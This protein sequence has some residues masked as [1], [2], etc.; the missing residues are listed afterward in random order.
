MSEKPRR[1]LAIIVRPCFEQDLQWVQL[2]YAHHVLT[3]AGTFDLTAPPLET[4]R[5]AW[6]EIA[7]KGWPYLVACAAADPSRI[8]GYA[9]AR[10][11]RDRAGYAHTFEDSI[12][13]SHTHTGFGIG[14]AMLSTLLNDLAEVGARQVVAVI[15][16]ADN[17]AS[18]R[19]HARF[20]FQEQGRLRDVGVKFGRTWDVVLMQ[21]GL[22]PTRGVQKDS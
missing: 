20:G 17:A 11:F 12:Y 13:V 10:P 5:A 1:R 16:D 14:R 21:R 18:I 22:E 15:G 19:L 3:G 7:G 2:I 8:L 9:Y 4:M 6:I